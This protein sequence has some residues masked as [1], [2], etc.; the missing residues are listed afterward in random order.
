MRNNSMHVFGCNLDQ[1][2]SRTADTYLQIKAM[3]VSD[4]LQETT[5]CRV[6]VPRKHSGRDEIKHTMAYY[7]DINIVGHEHTH[8]DIMLLIPL[9]FALFFSDSCS[10]CKTVVL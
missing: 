10:H 6:L 4:S 9:G 3:R 1:C 8:F 7:I 2:E 5:T